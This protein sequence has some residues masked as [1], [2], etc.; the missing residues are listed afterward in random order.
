MSQ[1]WIAGKNPVIEA[2]KADRKIE[3]IM[4]ADTAKKGAAQEIR[5][6]AGKKGIAVQE[7]SKK[8]LDELDA[9]VHQGVAAAVPAYQYAGMEDL[10]RKAEKQHEDP[11]FLVL[12]GVEDP[13]NLGSM[14]RTANASGVHGVIIPKRRAAGVTQTVVKTSAGAVEYVPVVRVTNINKTLDE[15]KEKGLWIAGTGIENASDYRQMQA[16]MPLALVIG[17]EGKGLSRLVKEA[18]DFLVQIPMHG[19]VTSLNAS[20]AGGVLMY[21]VMRKRQE[22]GRQTP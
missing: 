3:R 8:K 20:V 2:L 22:K 1:E 17:N 5:A 10:F 7:V 13:H 14:I 9:G 21:E 6:L 11:F 12:D 16:D 4:I 19:A 15:L 18:C